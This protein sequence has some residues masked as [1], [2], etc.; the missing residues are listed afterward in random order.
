MDDFA[1]ID[2]ANKNIIVGEN[3]SFF[4]VIPGPKP[5]SEPEYKWSPSANAI[6]DYV[7]SVSPGDSNP[8]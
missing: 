7:P 1:K 3:V 4:V 8:R 6:D 2:S 5:A